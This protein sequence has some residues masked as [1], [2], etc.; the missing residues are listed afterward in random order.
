MC[1]SQRGAEEQAG[2]LCLPNPDPGD[3]CQSHLGTSSTTILL[4]TEQQ[5]VCEV[6][7]LIALHILCV[8]KDTENQSSC[9]LGKKND[10][11]WQPA[12]DKEKSPSVTLVISVQYKT[13][14]DKKCKHIVSSMNTT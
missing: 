2:E 12:G 8:A 1:P 9:A 11:F 3:I 10:D 5:Q 6:P 7:E 4:N 14:C 13:L